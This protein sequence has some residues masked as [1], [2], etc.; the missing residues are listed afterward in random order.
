MQEPLALNYLPKSLS[1][2]VPRSRAISIDCFN[3]FFGKFTVYFYR[4]LYISPRFALIRPNL[5]YGS[6]TA[7]EPYTSRIL[8]LGVANVNDALSFSF[9]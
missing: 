6:D 3:C 5:S 8:N 2:V 7:S 9:I 1:D 4:H